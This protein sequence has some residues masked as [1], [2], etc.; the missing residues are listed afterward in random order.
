MKMMRRAVARTDLDAV[1]GNKRIRHVALGS[2]HRFAQS[3]PLGETGGDRR[4]QRAAG[5][6]GILCRDA[7]GREA[8]ERVGP[9][10]EVDALGAAAVTALDEYRLRPKREQALALLAHLRLVAGDRRIE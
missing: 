10:Q 1:G 5:A 8:G 2:A 3:K 9:D 7:V 4:G 6:V